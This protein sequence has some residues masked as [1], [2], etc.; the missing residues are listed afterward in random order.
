MPLENRQFCIRALRVFSAKCDTDDGD[1][2]H[3][4]ALNQKKSMESEGKWVAYWL[5]GP[6]RR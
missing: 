3:L 6:F 5:M 2:R 4:M 1:L